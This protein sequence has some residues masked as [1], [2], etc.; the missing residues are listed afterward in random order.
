M[1]RTD[2]GFAARTGGEMKRLALLLAVAT[3]ALAASAVATA[4]SGNWYWSKASAEFYVENQLTVDDE[5][6]VVEAYCR[7]I[8]RRWRGKYHHFRCAASDDVDRIWT[9]M[10]HPISRRS[11]RLTNVACDDSESEYY[12]DE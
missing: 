9:F 10:L 3:V 11:A 4:H 8:G 5:T 12:C 1:S 2:E 7:G 6:G